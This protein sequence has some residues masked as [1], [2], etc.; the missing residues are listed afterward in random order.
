MVRWLA[1]ALLVGCGNTPT[2]ASRPATAPVTTPVIAAPVAPALPA[3]PPALPT[4]TRETFEQVVEDTLAAVFETCVSMKPAK[5]GEHSIE[6]TI[7]LR[8]G[9]DPEIEAPVALPAADPS[10][11]DCLVDQL[12]G[13]ELPAFP[14][15]SELSF[16]YK[17][18]ERA[19]GSKVRIF[20]TM[21]IL[22][23]SPLQS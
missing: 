7:V 22:P 19:D 20:D 10:L 13:L 14:T 9:R 3:S 21:E 17:I 15:T 5:T 16:G 2:T 12:V 18:K 23:S 1:L 6:V 8:P 11:E 4:L